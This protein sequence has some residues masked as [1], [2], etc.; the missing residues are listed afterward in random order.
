MK[1][2]AGNCRSFLFEKY[3]KKNKKSFQKGI[4]KHKMVCY[5]KSVVR[6][7]HPHKRKEK[8]K[9][10][11]VRIVYKPNTIE[12]Q[13]FENGTEMREYR[14]LEDAQKCINNYEKLDIVAHVHFVD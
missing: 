8:N 7:R 2:A 14:N 4:D 12:A 1:G 11:K 3:L 13:V 9:M 6:E 10:T 5:N